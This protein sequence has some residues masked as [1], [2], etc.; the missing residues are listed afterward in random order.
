MCALSGEAPLVGKTQSEEHDGMF[1]RKNRKR[2]Y[3]M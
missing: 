3:E 2:S 1:L